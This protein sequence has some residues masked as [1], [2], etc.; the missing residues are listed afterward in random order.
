MAC[1]SFENNYTIILI[2]IVEGLWGFHVLGCSFVGV[3][4]GSLM[5]H[6]TF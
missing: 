2:N 6:I 4:L 5:G 3:P 1:K